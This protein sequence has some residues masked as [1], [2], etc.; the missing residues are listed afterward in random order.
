[1]HAHRKNQPDEHM[2]ASLGSFL[3]RSTFEIPTSTT[4]IKSGNAVRRISEPVY[5]VEDSFAGGD[6]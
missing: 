1:M 4:I 5:V 6:G 2:S 3:N